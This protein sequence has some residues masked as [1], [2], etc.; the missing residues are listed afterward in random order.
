MDAF[1][2][3]ILYLSFVDACQQHQQGIKKSFEAI[4]HPL[5]DCRMS[6]ADTI[7]SKAPDLPAHESHSEDE[8]TGPLERPALMASHSIGGT[9]FADATLDLDEAHDIADTPEATRPHFDVRHVHANRLKLCVPPLRHWEEERSTGFDTVSTPMETQT[10]TSAS[11]TSLPDTRAA[12]ERE[13]INF[14]S[15]ISGSSG[16]RANLELVAPSTLPTRPPRWPRDIPWTVSFWMLVPTCLCYSA[17]FLPKDSALAQH[18]LSFATLHAITWTTV[19]VISVSRL[20]YKSLPGGDG[21]DVRWSA[22][23]WVTTGAP[24]SVLVYAVLTLTVWLACP[25]IRW[26]AAVPAG[27]TIRDVCAFRR[28]NR[29]TQHYAGAGYASRIAFFQA[30]T[31]MALDIM[32]R[33][34]RRASFYRVLSAILLVQLGLLLLWRQALLGSLSTSSSSL[35]LLLATW[36]AGKWATGTVTRI[37]TL[38]ASA[39]VLHWSIQ[40][41]TRLI[42]EEQEQVNSNIIQS[43]NGNTSYGQGGIAQHDDDEASSED[44]S[45][46]EAYRTVDASVY[47]SVVAMD[48]E[49]LDDDYDDLEEE[50]V[51]ET[52]PPRSSFVITN[53]VGG[54]RDNSFSQQQHPHTSRT[55]VKT[56][57]WIGLTKNFGSIAHCGLLGGVAQFVWSQIRKIE[58]AQTILRDSTVS[59]GNTNN[60]QSMRVGDSSYNAA[61]L[62]LTNKIL[63][64]A[65]SF[66]RNHSDLAMTHVAAYH[67]GYARAA[68]DVATVIEQSGLEPILHEDITTHMCTCI[69][70]SMSGLIVL[71]TTHLLMHQRK[72]YAEVNDTHVVESMLFSFI[73]SYTLIFTALEPLRAAIK[74]SYVAFAQNPRCLSQAFPLIYYRLSRLSESNLT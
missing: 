13:K 57:L 50:A 10:E 66:V 32:S 41:S 65:R 14:H 33:S 23:L 74:A 31:G 3:A 9:F 71:I 64:L 22:A 63:V 46:P 51:M 48:E 20:L 28:W 72:A 36:A 1:L 49:M 70:G 47:Q 52:A 21:D 16:G 58:F 4:S 8:A 61:G 18:P 56:I 39:G 69:A 67:K 42:V 34:L 30:V 59:T 40:Q 15:I 29:R 17:F 5:A 11:P 12:S 73:L 43:G 55:T 2:A 25:S 60:F 45:I 24:V 35:M 68:R 44:A 54:R 27:Y 19:A 26:A 37:L 53:T 6:S 38:V 7:N 62:G